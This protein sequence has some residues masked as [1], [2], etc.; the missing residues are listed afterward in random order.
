[1][2]HTFAHRPGL[3][4]ESA[5][6]GTADLDDKVRQSVAP[7]P[8]FDGHRPATPAIQAV[9]FVARPGERPNREC[10]F[11]HIAILHQL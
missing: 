3:V 1:M 11:F 6:V 10:V 2:E 8:S 7:V 9:G 4:H 5:V